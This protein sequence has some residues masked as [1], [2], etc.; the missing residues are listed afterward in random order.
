MTGVSALTGL[1]SSGIDVASVAVTGRIDGSL[2]KTWN[3]AVPLVTVSTA[4][5]PEY[6]VVLT[7]STLSAIVLG[8]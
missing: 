7:G 5:T 1:A 3:G 6:T 4:G 2:E 8:G